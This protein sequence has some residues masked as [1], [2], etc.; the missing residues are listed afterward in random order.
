L[1]EEKLAG[2]FQAENSS[3]SSLKIQT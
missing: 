2:L 3:N 1:S